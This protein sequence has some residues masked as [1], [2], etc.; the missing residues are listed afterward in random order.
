MLIKNDKKRPSF[1]SYAKWRNNYGK[2]TIKIEKK[3]EQDDN[4]T[5]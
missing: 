5:S 4:I 2:Y 3:E 1:G